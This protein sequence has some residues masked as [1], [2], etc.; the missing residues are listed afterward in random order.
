MRHLPDLF[1]LRPEQLV[2][3][4]GFAEKSAAA[5]VA[6]IERASTVDLDRFLFALGIPEVGVSVGRD[7]AR[8]FGE[9]AALRRADEEELARVPGVGPKMATAIR[10]FLSEPHNAEVIDQLVDGRVT[11][12]ETE[13]AASVPGPLDG[14]KLVFTGGLASLTRE[15][16]KVIV[17]EAG[18]RVTGSV[19]KAT[20]YVVVGESP[21]SKAAKARELGVELLDESS[22]RALVGLAPAEPV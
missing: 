18:G 1:D 6:A 17:E 2:E 8:H 7:L 5:L 9:L 13:P 3:L 11:L 20:D 4:E 22:F 15:Q 21:G 14:K 12:R 16:A 19:S 10:Q